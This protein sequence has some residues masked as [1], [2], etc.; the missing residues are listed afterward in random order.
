MLVQNS[1]RV[2]RAAMIGLVERKRL[3]ASV[4]VLCATLAIS[5]CNKQKKTDEGKTY[6]PDTQA[7]QGAQGGGSSGGGSSDSG[8]SA[9]KPLDAPADTT[10]GKASKASDSGASDA[11]QGTVVAEPG[12]PV[13]HDPQPKPAPKPTSTS[14]HS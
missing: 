7:K 5:G 8:Q 10:N 3:L 11:T 13:Q 12:A 6:S 2:R 1:I 4:L 14:G 9:N